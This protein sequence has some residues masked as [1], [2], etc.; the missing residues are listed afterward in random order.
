MYD[1]EKYRYDKFHFSGRIVSEKTQ[2][3]RTG[4]TDTRS[5]FITRNEQQARHHL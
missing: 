1:Y 4:Y 2:Y 5:N 3:I